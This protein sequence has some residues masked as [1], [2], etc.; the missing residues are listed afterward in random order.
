MPL[1]SLIV[2]SESE[3][4]RIDKYLTGSI[5]GLSKGKYFVITKLTADT[6]T[7]K[8]EDTGVVYTAERKYFEKY[9]ERVN[10]YWSE[11]LKSYKIKKEKLKE[12]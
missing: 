8:S 2:P 12:N 7:Y 1:I 4:E 5:D 3:G 9:I 11:T 10:K 6:V